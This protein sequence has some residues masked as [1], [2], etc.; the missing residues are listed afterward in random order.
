[1]NWEQLGNCLNKPTDWWFPEKLDGQD[2]HG[3]AAKAVCATCPVSRP[4]LTAALER[5]ERHGIWGGAGGDL[6]RWL[7]RVWNAHQNDLDDEQAREDWEAALDVHR[8]ILAGE[9]IVI[10]RNGPGATHGLPV[11]YN[12]GCRCGP[13][14][15]SRRT[16][17][18]MSLVV[19][20]LRLDELLGLDTTERAS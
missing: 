6:L 3:T 5:G 8:R 4:C 13:C 2:N 11:T 18:R 15:R 17:G 9:N 20:Q 19:G 1:V 14:C 7:R 16:P 10:N 12:R